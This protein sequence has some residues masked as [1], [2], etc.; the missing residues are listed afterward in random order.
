MMKFAV[1]PAVTAQ[2]EVLLGDALQLD[3][4]MLR[5][6]DALAM[7]WEHSCR[8]DVTGKPTHTMAGSVPATVQKA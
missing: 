3:S 4:R 2:Q 8:L 6:V 5:L 1:R 7:D